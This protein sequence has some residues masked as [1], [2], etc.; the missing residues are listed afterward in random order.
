MV[1]SK[2]QKT[3]RPILPYFQ[4]E[5]EP[6]LF[7]VLAAKNKLLLL[8]LYGA[9]LLLVEIYGAGFGCLENKSDGSIS[10]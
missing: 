1:I 3:G 8:T 5:I 10:N 7:F 9:D 2:I 6:S 4:L